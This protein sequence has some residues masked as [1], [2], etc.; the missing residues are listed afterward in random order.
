LASGQ[1]GGDIKNHFVRQF[2]VE[3][4]AEGVSST[5]DQHGLDAAAGQGPERGS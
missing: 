2:P 5:F 3:E 1:K 4:F